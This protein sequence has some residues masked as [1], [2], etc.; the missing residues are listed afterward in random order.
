MVFILPPTP[1]NIWI[2]GVLL[3]A[4]FNVAFPTET[5]YGLAG[6]IF[7]E[8]AILRIYKIKG[9]PSTNPVIVHVPNVD[10]LYK[11]N[12]TQM[13][14]HEE[15]VFTALVGRFSPGPL[16][17]LVRANKKVVSEQIRNGSHFVG[18]RIPAH[19]IALALLISAGVPI[20]APS[21]NP[22][23][24]VSPTRPKHVLDDYKECKM[25]MP[26]LG[27]NQE[28]RGKCV[29]VEST[30]VKIEQVIDEDGVSTTVITILRPG[31]I[32]TKQLQEFLVT[33]GD[34]IPLQW[35][36][37]NYVHSVNEESS[38]APGQMLKHYSPKM[39]THIAK[40]SAI[41]VFP[42]DKMKAV[43]VASAAMIKKH[44]HQYEHTFELADTVE[45]CANQLYDV[46]RI[47][48]DY[49][50]RCKLTAILIC[51]DDIC[52]HASIDGGDLDD[53]LKD[54]LNRA[55]SGDDPVQM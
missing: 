38:D 11:H 52:Q 44:G 15:S 45:G 25:F 12:L 27:D 29:G 1:L 10:S 24:G 14:P 39:P 37:K 32:G 53:A 17:L 46:M 30:I 43:L 31:A 47:A 4:G 5:V 7:N 40:E 48:D 9:R 26:I 20:A 36:I 6:N 23:G 13:T 8:K 41:R 51:I 34:T 50:Q 28:D 49:T 54:K 55:S 16:T 3:R 19:P 21:A 22:S 2:L 35:T 18:I 42:G 33:L